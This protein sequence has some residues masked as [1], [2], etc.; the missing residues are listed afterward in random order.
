MPPEHSGGRPLSIYIKHIKKVCTNNDTH[1]I[2]NGGPS[3]PKS[4]MHLLCSNDQ[5]LKLLVPVSQLFIKKQY[6]ILF[7][8]T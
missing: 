4:A 7:F 8:L 3:G 2:S 5:K 6:T 1:M